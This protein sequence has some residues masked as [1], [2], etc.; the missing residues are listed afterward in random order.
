M[1]YKNINGMGRLWIYRYT[2][3]LAKELLGMIRSKYDSIPI[4]DA[5]IKLDG[6]T[7]RQEATREKEDLI[8][9]IRET[10]EETGQTAQMKK[11]MENVE[12]MQQIFQRI[13]LPIYIG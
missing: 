7:L 1:Q 5:A 6:D 2:L 12:A 11:Q 13:P 4:P 3:A 8:K 9:E 10:L